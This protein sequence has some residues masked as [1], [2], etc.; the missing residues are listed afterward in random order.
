MR[1]KR[2]S[3][4]LSASAGCRRRTSL[5]FLLGETGGT[6]GGGLETDT[7]DTRCR[8]GPDERWSGGAVERRRRHP[9]G[10]KRPRDL[11]FALHAEEQIPR[12]ARDDLRTGSDD[13]SAL[14]PYRFTVSPFHRFTV[15]PFRRSTVPP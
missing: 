8:P 14:P 1:A 7:I 13:R 9:E 11:L 2:E 12:F 5:A 10:A 6:A 15:P 3:R 4:T